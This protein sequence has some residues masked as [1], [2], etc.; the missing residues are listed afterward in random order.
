MSQ[1]SPSSMSWIQV[2]PV[3]LPFVNFG[4]RRTCLLNLEWYFTF[5][6]TRIKPGKKKNGLSE[7]RKKHSSESTSEPATSGQVVLW[8]VQNFS[9]TFMWTTVMATGHPWEIMDSATLALGPQHAY[10][11]AWDS[12]SPTMAET[13]KQ[14]CGILYIMSKSFFHTN[15]SSRGQ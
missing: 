11:T 15:Y 2:S 9:S 14:L 1:V 8:F 5:L 13:K 12:K 3:L 6:L 7:P 4:A 10:I